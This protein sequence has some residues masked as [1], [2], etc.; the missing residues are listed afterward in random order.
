MKNMSTPGWYPD[1]RDDG[2]ERFWSGTEWTAQVRPTETLS[3]ARVHSVMVPPP[4]P[5]RSN[6]VLWGVLTL[7]LA[8]LG[9]GSWWLSTAVGPAPATSPSATGPVPH[10]PASRFPTGHGHAHESSA[11]PSSPAATQDPGS[12]KVG[13]VLRGTPDCP[14]T[15]T[16]STGALGEDG[17]ITSAGGLSFPAIAGFTPTKLDYGFIHQ[18]NTVVK[19]YPESNNLMAAVA[20]G[21][22]ETSEGF[23]EVIPAAARVV[24]CL[25]GR[26]VFHQPGSMAEIV[27]I[28][29]DPRAAAVWL[30][31]RIQIS[32]IA[33]VNTNNISVFTH[34]ADN[35]IMHVALVVEPDHDPEGDTAIWTAIEDLRLP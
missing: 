32:G 5:R 18:A 19:R 31:T 9:G 13:D 3:G 10:P 30:N 34:L 14:N 17:R 6:T 1:P 26:G 33:G 16:D 7:V 28:N 11:A 24:S 35:G 25:L 8:L 29:H 15:A 2:Q 12:L 22:L 20:V 27:E 4:S 21:T 23:A